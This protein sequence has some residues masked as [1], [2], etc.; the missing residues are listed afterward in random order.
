MDDL[1][2]VQSCVK[3]DKQSWDTFVEK[4]SRLIYTYIRSILKLKGLSV[5]QENIDDLFQEIFLALVKDDF[6][7]LKTFKAKNG[8]SLASWLRQVTVNFTIDYIR[9][10][11]P[12]TSLEEQ[13]QEGL[14]LKEILPDTSPLPGEML[15]QKERFSQLKDCIEELDTEDKYFLELYIHRGFTLAELEGVLR[16]SRA[17]VDM[18]KYNIVARLKECFKHK[19][20]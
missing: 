14:S 8:C 4:Y 13:D 9:K 2:F 11:K 18:R 12:V 5:S 1:G 3:G 15:M 20:F 19:G 6:K 10:L 7:K 16:I 17:A